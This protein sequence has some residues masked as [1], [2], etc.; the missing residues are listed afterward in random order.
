MHRLELFDSIELIN[1]AKLIDAIE[2]FGSIEGFSLWP[3]RLDFSYFKQALVRQYF[4]N[5][6]HPNQICI[7][8]TIY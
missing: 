7:V 3:D 4:L 8:V 6:V 2:L 5:L 1:S